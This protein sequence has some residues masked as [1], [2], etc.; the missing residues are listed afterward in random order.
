[1]L[2]VILLIPIAVL[3]TVANFL[4]VTSK[5][6]VPWVSGIIILALLVEGTLFSLIITFSLSS[7]F[8]P[9]LSPYDPMRVDLRSMR[10]PPSFDHWFG[11]DSTGRDVFARVLY[12]GRVSIFIGL[13]SAILSA[14]VGIAVG[15]YAG[16][17]GGWIDVIALRVSEIFMSFPQIILVLLLVSITGQSLFNLMAIFIVTGIIR[18]KASL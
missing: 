4:E 16:Y 5:T 17:K 9:I 1:M 2:E 8:A 10:Q 15:C 6:P 12:G 3:P 7:I 14:V 13:G 11:T 18:I